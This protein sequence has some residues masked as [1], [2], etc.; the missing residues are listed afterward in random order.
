VADG[1]YTVY[2]GNSSA[3]SDLTAAG[4]FHVGP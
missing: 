2:V 1:D 4:T 3:L